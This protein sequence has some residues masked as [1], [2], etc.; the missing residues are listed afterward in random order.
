MRP[1]AGAAVA[2]AEAPGPPAPPGERSFALVHAATI[3]IPLDMADF[4]S[5]VVADLGP[6]DALVVLKEFDP[7]MAGQALFVREGMPRTLATMDF[8][9]AT[10]QRQLEGQGGLQTF[11]HEAAARSASTSSSAT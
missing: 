6:E 11:F 7:A 1:E 4:G 2:G 10:L 5:D 3:P 9:Q 8:S